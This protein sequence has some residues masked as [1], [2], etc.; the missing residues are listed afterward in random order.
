MYCASRDGIQSSDV[1]VVMGDNVWVMAVVILMTV[2][3][4]MAVVILMTLL[5]LIP[6]AV[7]VLMVVVGGAEIVH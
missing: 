6:M 2:A 4:L 1:G 3:V 7:S 5:V